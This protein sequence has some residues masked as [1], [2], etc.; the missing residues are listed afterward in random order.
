MAGITPLRPVPSP[1]DLRLIKEFNG[2]FLPLKMGNKV[3]R[4]LV[5]TGACWTLM[6]LSLVE[7]CGLKDSMTEI[8]EG[9][10]VTI[11]VLEAEVEAEGGIFLNFVVAVLPRLGMPLLG[12][13]F[14]LRYG[15]RLVLDPE[16]PLMTARP[17]RQIKMGLMCGVYK[18]CL[19]SN[20]LVTAMLD[21]GSTHCFISQ[22][23][24]RQFRLKRKF[25]MPMLVTMFDGSINILF[26]RVSKAKINIDGLHFAPD[27]LVHPNKNVS[28]IIG[29]NLLYSSVLCLEKKEILM[30][31]VNPLCVG[32]EQNPKPSSIDLTPPQFSALNSSGR[33]ISSSGKKRG[34]PLFK[35]WFKFLRRFRWSGTGRCSRN[36]ATSE[37]LSGLGALKQTKSEREM[38]TERDTNENQGSENGQGEEG[39]E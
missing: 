18:K 27:L 34:F 23:L 39:D 17:A 38:R 15:C 24:A 9:G 7:E 13:N 14:L 33:L 6:S 30:G 26:R 5:D 35:K 1:V 3:V 21:T 22:A 32:G 25:T 12:M 31:T 28:L 29:M 20:R 16:L 10:L 11:G 19:L 8:Q 4:F 36:V 37:G 2:L